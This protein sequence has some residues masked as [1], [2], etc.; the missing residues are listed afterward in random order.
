MVLCRV[1]CTDILYIYVAKEEIEVTILLLKQFYHTHF[2][3]LSDKTLFWE[4]NRYSHNE[5]KVPI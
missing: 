4:Y 5:T 2:S 1:I 3:C